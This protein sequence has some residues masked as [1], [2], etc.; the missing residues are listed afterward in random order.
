MV[1]RLQAEV[2]PASATMGCYVACPKGNLW[3]EELG[4]E[5]V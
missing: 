4:A 5:P 1:V 3:A 2:T